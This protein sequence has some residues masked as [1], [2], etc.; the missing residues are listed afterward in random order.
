MDIKAIKKSIEIERKMDTDAIEEKKK[1][2]DN[3]EK[4]KENVLE[5]EGEELK[6]VCIYDIHL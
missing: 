3:K 6:L 4:W 2:L 1:M 5:W